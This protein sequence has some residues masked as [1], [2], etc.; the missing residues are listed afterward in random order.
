M[1]MSDQHTKLTMSIFNAL[2]KAIDDAYNNIPEGLDEV[3][4]NSVMSAATA[5]VVFL[6][7]HY[8]VP[9][10]ELIDAISGN[11]NVQLTQ[12]AQIAELDK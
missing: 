5:H 6:A 8:D 10:G 7:I 9:K 11:W 3:I 1:F 12:L 4:V 2:S